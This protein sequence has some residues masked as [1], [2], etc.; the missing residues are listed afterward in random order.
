MAADATLI[1][2]VKDIYGPTDYS[3]QLRL[4]KEQGDIL[5]EGITKTTDTIVKEI[6]EREQA[7]KEQNEKNRLESQAF[8]KKFEKEVEKRADELNNDGGLQE[9][10]ADAFRNSLKGIKENYDG[11][12]LLE[13]GQPQSTEDK[14]AQLKEFNKAAGLEKEIVKA[15]TIFGTAIKTSP[16]M[17]QE[18]KETYLMCLNSNDHDNVKSSLVDGKLQYEITTPEIIQ[19]QGFLTTAEVEAGVEPKYV[20]IP[21]S[22]KTYSLDELEELLIPEASETETLILASG[23]AM[24]ELGKEEKYGTVTQ[25]M[26]QGEADKLA[27]EIEKDP[28]ILADLAVRGDFMPG[29]N[30][31]KPQNDSGRWNV[32]SWASDLQEHPTLNMDVYTTVGIDV[33]KNDDG[34]VSEEEAKIVW[35]KEN[36]DR[37]IEVLVNPKAEGYNHALSSAELGM[38]FAMQNEQYYYDGQA[39]TNKEAAGRA[40]EV[41]GK[42]NNTGSRFKGQ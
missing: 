7:Y 22:T 25:S 35:T 9:D 21:A 3:N 17:S 24:K 39:A 28:K 13:N 18:A 42:Q 8:D 1:S 38:W 15:R 4:Q 41:T 16:G 26:L 19:Q 2:S 32:G 36:R 33:D 34:I 14:E 10:V 6:Q 31:V 29:R 27:A 5:R 20:T 12:T 37:I 11:Y 40:N 23:T 30:K